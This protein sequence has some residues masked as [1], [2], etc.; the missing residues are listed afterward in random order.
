MGTISY[1]PPADLSVERRLNVAL[2][3]VLER[4]LEEIASGRDVCADRVQD[5][6][7][8]TLHELGAD[9]VLQSDAHEDSALCWE[10][11]DR[12]V[13]DI[14]THDTL[15]EGAEEKA[16]IARI[17]RDTALAA[18]ETLHREHHDGRFPS[19][20]CQESVCR[21]AHLGFWTVGQ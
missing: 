7:I 19:R 12:E 3:G 17:D 5:D 4:L 15:I 21:E 20:L 13:V 1:A 2:E 11:L 10:R 6:L 8:D 18:L 14:E 9:V 16:D